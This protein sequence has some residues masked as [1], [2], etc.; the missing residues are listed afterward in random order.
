MNRTNC[1]PKPAGQTCSWRKVGGLLAPL[2]MATGLLVAQL[3]SAQVVYRWTNAEGKPEVSHSIPADVVHKGYEVLDGE[4]MNRLDVVPPQMT[5]DEYT[6]QLEREKAR[7]VCQRTLNRIYSRYEKLED[8]GETEESALQKLDVRVSN[9]QQDLTRA[10]RELAKHESAA[11]SQ[12]R[13][14]NTV[15]KT[16]LTE[17]TSANSQ[18]A[19][20]ERELSQ[21]EQER[22]DM[23]RD[24]DLERLMFTANDC[25]VEESAS[26]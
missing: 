22:E 26:R 17:L 14:G 11:A 8:I 18:I 20:L 21:R 19:T 12:E 10:K 4:T 3:A 1:I 15:S 2:V 16:L 23:Q 5:D 25:N 6:A 13:Q 9:A 24:F 7:A